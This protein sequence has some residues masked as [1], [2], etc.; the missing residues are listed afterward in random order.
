MANRGFPFM[1]QRKPF[2]CCAIF[3]KNS[4]GLSWFRAGFINFRPGKL[5]LKLANGD[6]VTE[7][8]AN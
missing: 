5:P 1:W 4:N 3:Y 6:F 8:Q 2:F 7:Y